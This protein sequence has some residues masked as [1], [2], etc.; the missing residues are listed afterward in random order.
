MTLYKILVAEIKNIM[1]LNERLYFQDKMS[2]L[3]ELMH[4]IKMLDTAKL[5][6]YEK[7]YTLYKMIIEATE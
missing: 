1:I 7:T 3:K 4:L 6:D 5:L 2:R